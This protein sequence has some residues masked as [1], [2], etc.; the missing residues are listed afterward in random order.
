MVKQT[1]SVLARRYA[2][3]VRKLAASSST[4][5][6]TFYPAIQELCNGLLDTRGLAFRM[7]TGTTE[8]RSTGGIDRPDVAIYDGAG[9]FMAVAGEVKTPPVDVVTLAA[10]TERNDQVGR[11]LAQTG[12]IILC[13]VRSFGLLALRPGGSRRAGRPVPPDRREL[14][15]IVELWT[16]ESEM[17]VGR[18]ISLENVEALSMLLERAVTEF[19]P[20]ST[21]ETLARILALQAREAKATLPGHFDKVK[22]LLDDYGLA[23]GVTFEGKEG[24]D[25][26]RSSLIQTAFYGLFAGWT[27]WHRENDGSEFEWER[28]DKYLKIPFL[29]KLFYEFRHPD[30]LEELNLAPHLDRATATLARVDR[31]EFFSRFHLPNIGEDIEHDEPSAPEIVAAAI[32]YFYEPFLEAFDPHLR[33]ELGV[34]YTPPEIVRYQVG[35]IDRLLREEMGCAR[36]FADDSVIVLDPCCGTGAYLIEVIRHIA[37]QLHEEGED[38]ALGAQ[39]LEAVCG[40][41]V[42]FEILTAPFVIAQLQL[43]LVLSGLGATPGARQRPAVF[44]TNA[45][46]GWDGP[47]QIKLNFPELQTEHDAASQVKRGARIIVVLGNPPYNR[48]AGMAIKEEADLVDHYKGISR[49]EEGQ[50]IGQSAL[51]ARWGVRKHLLD[52][53]YIRFIRLAE[54]RIGEV[55][56]YGIVSFISNASFLAG[57]SH[58]LMRDSL[59]RNFHAIWVDNLNGDK[60]RTG[61]LIPRGLPGEGTADQSVFTTDRDSRGIQVGTCI[62]TYLK[63]DAAQTPS[64]E[65]QL[66]YRDFWGRANDKRRSLLESIRLEST[67]GEPPNEAALRPE[68]PRPYEQIRP[69]ETNRWIFAPRDVNGGYEA[70]PALDELFPVAFQGVNPNR[71]LEGS[72]IDTDRRTLATRARE[73][74]EATR[75]SDIRRKHPALCEPR[76][77]YVPEA[78][79]RTLKQKSRFE[80]DRVVPYLLF[81]LDQRWLYYETEA[82]LLNE[83]RPEFWE[84]LEGNEF[85]LTVPQP[86]QISESRPLLAR[87]LADLHVHDRGSVCFPKRIAPSPDPGLFRAEEEHLHQANLHAEAWRVVKRGWRLRGGLGGPD[88]ESLVAAL[89]RVTLA[90]LHSPLFETD[91]AD[92]LAQGWAQIPIP[93]N[94]GLFKTLAASGDIVAQLLDSQARPDQAIKGIL[95]ERF[96][97]LGVLTKAGARNVRAED[98]VVSVSYFAAAP[99]KWLGRDYRVE[100][101]PLLPWGGSTGDLFVNSEV[102]FA[103][104]PEGVWRYE[105][106]GYPVLKKWLGYRHQSRRDGNALT[107]AEAGHFRS[108]VQRIAALLALHDELDRLYEESAGDAFTAEELAIR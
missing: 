53:F 2:S 43:Y 58:P 17:R 37:R 21:P 100:E 31:D 77:R 51:F 105:L 97:T 71:G 78:V 1:P 92:G 7:R 26:F 50:Q 24:E 3:E 45:L 15:A 33:K 6:Q 38:N 14:L 5:E 19:A 63:M 11:Y 104:V 57:R 40:R 102:Y 101:Q 29:G 87:I 30:R 28:L 32:T 69:T 84:N 82:K 13:N 9:T 27:L 54:K 23:L 39:V 88:A 41:L 49:D 47:E 68:G 76:A 62:S 72:V 12:V 106:G 74:F 90:L 16:S 83:R 46:T 48:F 98:L 36:G 67:R 108:M 18:S 91:H 65:T 94:Q 35:K 34:W 52:D 55:A 73:Y 99:G 10:S 95:G 79:W 44:L 70:W 85:L 56:E 66:Y 81:P 64:T 25:F 8:S 103:N 86:R 75:F 61:K 22:G 80:E 59:L 42:G 93:R 107:L 96:R 20:I 60:Y 89:F 4:N